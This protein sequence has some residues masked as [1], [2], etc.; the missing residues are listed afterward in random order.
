MFSKGLE[1]KIR[2]KDQDDYDDESDQ[3]NITETVTSFYKI[4]RQTNQE[5]IDKK[6]C[7]YYLSCHITVRKIKNSSY[8]CYINSY[9]KLKRKVCRMA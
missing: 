2:P 4:P 8:S 1:T 6:N 3:V 5:K 7:S 9:T